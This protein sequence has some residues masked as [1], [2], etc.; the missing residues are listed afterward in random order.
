[1]K[2][3]IITGSSKGLG[4]VIAEY[5]SENGYKVWLSGRNAGALQAAKSQIETKTGN[6]VEVSTVDLA[7]HDQCQRYATLL[8]ERCETVDVLVNNAGIFI[9]DQLTQT[10][11]TLAAQMGLNFYAAHT[12]TQTLMPKFKTQ[13]FGHIFNICSAVNRQPR[14]EAASYTISKF[15]MLGYHKVLHESLRPIGVKVTALFPG[16][17]NTSSWE[18]MNV[19]RNEFIQP[20]DI[21][22]L[23]VTITKMHPGTVPA[24]IDLAAGNPD[25]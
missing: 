25:Y 12:I 18:G 3:A 24:E 2:N 23:I 7:D 4:R 10:K 20:A 19:P 1:M 14:V 11:H 9:P 13:K 15:A 21:A 8:F 17:I 6:P 22:S 5:L 16:S